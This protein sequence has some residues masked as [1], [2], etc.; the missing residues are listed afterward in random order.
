LLERY[1]LAAN[2]TTK[3]LVDHDLARFEQSLEDERDVIEDLSRLGVHT[4]PAD[5]AGDPILSR[6]KFVI[7]EI[8]DVN[9]KNAVLAANGLEFAEAMLKTILPPLTYESLGTGTP[10]MPAEAVISLRG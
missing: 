1:L 3:T 2:R 7:R 4:I 8:R 6:L 10:V 5:P 9:R